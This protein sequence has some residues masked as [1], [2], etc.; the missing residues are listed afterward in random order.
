MG[1]RGCEA[2]LASWGAPCHA[3]G[4]TYPQGSC[5]TSPPHS[6]F[7]GPLALWTVAMGRGAQ[8]RRPGHGS[9]PDSGHWSSLG[10]VP[11][12]ART[13][14]QCVRPDAVLLLTQQAAPPARPAALPG[15]TP[16]LREARILA[17]WVGECSPLRGGAVAEHHPACLSPGQGSGLWA[18]DQPRLTT[19]PRP[20]W[21]PA[22]SAAGDKQGDEDPA[23]GR[24]PSVGCGKPS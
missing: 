8:R 16:W 11:V 13:G 7:L 1:G 3:R 6:W 2:G 14:A 5:R 9:Q 21:V 23:G 22:Q 15:E 20:H 18:L 10:L 12:P 4:E 24:H 17:R 19:R